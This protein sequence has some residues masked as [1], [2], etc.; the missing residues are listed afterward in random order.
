MPETAV[1]EVLAPF[2][3]PEHLIPALQAVQEAEGWLSSESLRAVA[4]RLGVPESSVY[5]VASFY[6]QFYLSPQGKHK[7]RVCLGTACH[8]RGSGSIL[9]AVRDKLGIEPGNSTADFE[10][11]LERVACVGSCALAPVVV[12]DDRV[13]GAMTPEKTLQVLDEICNTAE[14]AEA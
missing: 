9:A 8:V 13:Y 11:N 6:S 7:I 3:Q 1:A 14:S 12:I 10:F 5:G 2:S 4:A